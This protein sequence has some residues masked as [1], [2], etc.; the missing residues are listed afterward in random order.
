MT[1]T[2]VGGPLH[3]YAQAHDTTSAGDPLPHD[4]T[5]GP[6]RNPQGMTD[7]ALRKKPAYTHVAPV[8]DLVADKHVFKRTLHD[9]QITMST[10][11]LLSVSPSIW[12]MVHEATAT[13][14]VAVKAEPTAQSGCP[15]A[16]RSNGALQEGAST[17]PRG[18]HVQNRQSGSM[19]A[20]AIVNRLLI[21]S[22]II[23]V[24]C[25]ECG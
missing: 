20:Y 10:A 21:V 12:R 16:P 5:Y 14:R 25:Q 13:R 11:K 9:T 15:T 1:A 23:C 4:F 8:T 2:N 22:L 19:F 6:G 17:Q 3:P 24:S 7:P 18:R